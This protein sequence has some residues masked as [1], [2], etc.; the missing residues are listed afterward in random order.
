MRVR[1]AMC[2]HGIVNSPNVFR[3]YIFI[4]H[5]GNAT[6]NVVQCIGVVLELA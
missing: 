5:T 1:H 3:L 4:Y 6:L 2:I